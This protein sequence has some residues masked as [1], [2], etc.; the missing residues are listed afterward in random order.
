VDKFTVTVM[1][2]C[3]NSIGG[4]H[5]ACPT[6]GNSFTYTTTVSVPRVCVKTITFE[7]EVFDAELELFKSLSPDQTAVVFTPRSTLCGKL[8]INPNAAH[9]LDNDILDDFQL[10]K[11]CARAARQAGR[12]LPIIPASRLTLLATRV[13]LDRSR[14]STI[15]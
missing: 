14:S 5:I 10:C 9:P 15:A 8:T 12:Q 1:G 3:Q 7:K 11:V 13:G 2:A 6:T 4:E